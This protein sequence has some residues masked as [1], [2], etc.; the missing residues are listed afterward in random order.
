MVF[1]G[2]KAFDDAVFDSV[3][4]AEVRCAN[5]AIDIRDLQCQSLINAKNA[6]IFSDD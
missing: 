1:V 5:R 3:Q 6:G 4:I 2:I